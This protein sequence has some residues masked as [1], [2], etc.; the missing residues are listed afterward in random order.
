M[1]LPTVILLLAALGAGVFAALLWCR[2]QLLTRDLAALTGR[3]QSTEGRITFLAGHTR[4][5]YD[6]WAATH[7]GQLLSETCAGRKTEHQ[8][9]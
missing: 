7:P 1:T 4:R 9:P 5:V 8:H 2:V 6:A 3:V